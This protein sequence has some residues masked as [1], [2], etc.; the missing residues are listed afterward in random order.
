MRGLTWVYAPTTLLGMADSCIGGKSSINVGPYKNL[1]GTF[2]PPQTV[3]IDTDFVT[4]L[5]TA[6][7]VAGLAEAAKICFCR[8]AEA[9]E[10]YRSL[11]PALSMDRDGFAKIVSA[12]LA[13]KKWFIEI[14]E[15]DKKERLLLNFGHTFGHAI[16]G[17]S[18][19]RVSHGVAVGVGM[20]CSL[21]LG[22][23]MGRDY[24]AT[25]R[26]GA[27]RQHV[28]DLLGAIKERPEALQG[29]TSA[30]LFDRFTADKKHKTDAYRLV[31]VTADG[32][33][34]LISMPKNDT[35]K[36][37]ITASMEE[38]LTELRA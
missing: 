12:S 1:V 23:R 24:A 31:T 29:V 33:A 3:L 11:K 7:I 16:E 2:N 26:V 13:S 9:W 15:F 21:S 19:F 37:Q 5:N 34:E 35:A 20:L 28:R 6:Q 17:A 8:G 30:D 36:A 25:P 22:K 14:D 18:H 4:T 38:V 27:L 32:N 10:T